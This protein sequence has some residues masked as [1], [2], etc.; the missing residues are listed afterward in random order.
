VFSISTPFSG[1]K[2]SGYGQEKG[3]LGILEYTSQKS[4][5][6]GLNESPMPW[7]GS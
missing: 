3:R 6:W 5:Y 1:V 2:M 7:A 4:F